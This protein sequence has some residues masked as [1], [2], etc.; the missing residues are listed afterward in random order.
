MYDPDSSVVGGS[1]E[2]YARTHIE[3]MLEPL[4]NLKSA[5]DELIFRDVTKECKFFLEE[6]M[7]YLKESLLGRRVKTGYSVY[8]N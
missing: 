7:D 5:A 8:L 6:H 2:P 1:A 3:Y 4:A